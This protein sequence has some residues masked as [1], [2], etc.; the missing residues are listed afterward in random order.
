MVFVGEFEEEIEHS[1][2]GVIRR[3]TVSH[4][5]YWLDRWFNIFRFNEPDGDLRNFY[6]NINMPPHFENDV[7]DYVDL[8]IDVLVW[9]DFTF[10]I[11]DTDEFRENALRYNYPQELKSKVESS[12]LEIVDLLNKRKF[13]FDY[14]S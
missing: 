2:L 4:E 10:E 5:Y 12:I 3:G 14:L 8:D 6:C 7:L 1:N 13:P 9:K 11:L